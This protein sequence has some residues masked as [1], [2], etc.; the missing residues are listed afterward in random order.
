MYFSRAKVEIGTSAPE[1]KSVT[2]VSMGVGLWAI[3]GW[4]N[5]KTT[6]A[7]RINSHH[8]EQQ[9][10]NMVRSGERKREI[11]ASNCAINFLLNSH[12]MKLERPCLL[13]VKSTGEIVFVK[14]HM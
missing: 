14:K 2:V 3:L 9:S 13:N 5:K 1:L 10:G 11:N 7:G 12:K 6:S 8:R 4:V